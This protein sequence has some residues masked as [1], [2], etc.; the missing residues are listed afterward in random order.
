VAEVHNTPWGERH[1]YVFDVREQASPWQFDFD[2][3]FHVSPFMPMNQAYAW[4]F[5]TPGEY[6]SVHMVSRQDGN[7]VFDASLGLEYRPITRRVM[8]SMLVRHPLM[9]LKVAWGIYWQAF[10]L[11]RKRTPFHPHPNAITKDTPA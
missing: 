3:E 5:D 11:W 6:I 10:K 2:K 4:R 8:R 9:T 7:V 1:C